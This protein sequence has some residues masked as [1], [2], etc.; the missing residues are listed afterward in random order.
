MSLAKTGQTQGHS[1][2]AISLYTEAYE[3]WEDIGYSIRASD[4]LKSAADIRKSLQEATTDSTE[5]FKVE[6]DPFLPSE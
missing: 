4:A 5:A 2:E 1:E 6:E 3:V